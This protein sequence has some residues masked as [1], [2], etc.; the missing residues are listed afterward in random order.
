M[1]KRMITHVLGLLLLVEGVL[2]LFPCIVAIFY[3]EKTIYSYLISIVVCAAVG[4]I[5]SSVKYSSNKTIYA[6][7][8]LAIVSLSWILL[9]LAGALPFF[10]S[11]EIPNYLDALFET[12]SGFTTTG[13]SIL[14]DIEAMS[15]SNLFWRSFTHWVGGMGVLVFAM[16]VIPLAGG[17]G[18]LHMMK[19]ESP[20]PEVGKLVPKS[21]AT[22][23]IL[24]AIYLVL[25]VIEIV[26]LLCG[27]MSLFESLTTA[28]GTAGTGGFGVKNDSI[29]GF[30]SYSQIV[31]TIFMAL[32]GINFNLY[33]LV[34]CAKVKDA[35]KSEELRAY[36]GIMIS[37]IVVIFINIYRL[38]GSVGEA[39]R[40]AA[41]QVSSIMTTTGFTT[42]NYDEWPVLSKMILLLLMCIG[43][44]AGS[45]GGGFKVSRILLLF[46][47]AR[48]EL[49]RMGHP[50]NVSVVKF[51]GK[52]VS[53]ETIH[54]T[55][56]YLVV[57][58]VIFV[59][60]LLIVSFDKQ[61]IVTNVTAVIATFNNIGPGLEAVGAIG[62]FSVFNPISKIVF[63]IDMLL[64][65]LE[66]FP[67]IM[68]FFMPIK[69][70]NRRPAI[71]SNAID[72]D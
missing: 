34:L 1:N 47:S 30:S 61:S 37:A 69:H 17:G 38:F 2:M 33:F 12:V 7:D 20:G 24:Y 18:N 19:A 43:A 32:F 58:I 46:K 53:E 67:I 42:V 63:I 21:T 56:A 55:S 5:M 66:I 60:S 39:L 36:L 6:R 35:L 49:K 54:N 13:S 52:R 4:L 8:G 64:G 59:V 68:L 48:R 26:L 57:Y 41:F 25:T 3:H 31:I 14:T 71:P 72:D 65:R 29:A 27:D 15:K 70:K 22:A 51:S 62:N 11:R 50:R 44:S 10:I 9:S 16:A 28:F 45:T 23:R 40:A